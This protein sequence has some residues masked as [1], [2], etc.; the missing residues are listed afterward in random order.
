VCLLAACGSRDDSPAS[1]SASG[2]VA[3]ASP[4]VSVSAAVDSTVEA[5]PAPTSNPFGLLVAPPSPSVGDRVF[6]PTAPMMRRKA[7]G[8]S[9]AMR[10]TTVVATGADSVVVDGRGA[11]DYAVHP[12]YLIPIAPTRTASKPNQPVIVDWAGV[13]RSGVVRRQVKDRVV[14]RFTDG[15]FSE[16]NVPREQLMP[17]VEGLRPG[18]YAILDEGDLRTHWLL[19]ARLPEADFARWFVV[20]WAG[21][22]RIVEERLLAPMPPRFEPDVDDPVWAEEHGRMRPAVVKS[23]DPP[24]RYLVQFARAGRPTASGWGHLMPRGPSSVA[25]SASAKP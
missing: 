10:S 2:V 15:D 9:M 8:A 22:T 1:T 24:G 12:G 11:P 20:G 4:A 14:V 7:I 6:A 18:N 19:V 21:E 3:P 13:L 5:A 17:R 23:A 16:R 25:A